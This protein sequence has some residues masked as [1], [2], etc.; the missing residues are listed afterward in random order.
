[1]HK[2]TFIFAITLDCCHSALYSCFT[3]N[4]VPTSSPVHLVPECFHMQLVK[5]A[6]LDPMG[7]IITSENYACKEHNFISI[8]QTGLM[9]VCTVVESLFK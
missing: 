2:S 4:A 5:T 3:K 9:N 6:F 1:M 8:F 7:N